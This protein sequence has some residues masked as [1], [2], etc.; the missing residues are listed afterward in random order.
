M[1][2]L[3]IHERLPFTSI[4]S[5]IS[6][7]YP[8]LVRPDHVCL[9]TEGKEVLCAFERGIFHLARAIYGSRGV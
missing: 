6:V 2:V 8:F 4:R 7:L 1:K 5:L 3:Y 9:E